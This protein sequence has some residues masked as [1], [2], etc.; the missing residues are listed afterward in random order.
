MAALQSSI[1]AGKDGVLT[2]SVS[3]TGHGKTPL[4]ETHAGAAIL[5]SPAPGTPVD[6]YNHWQRLAGLFRQIK[7][8]FLPLVATWNIGKIA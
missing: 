4:R 8:E 3:D 6:P 7:V 1:C 5:V 2:Q